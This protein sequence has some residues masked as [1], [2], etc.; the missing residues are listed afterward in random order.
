MPSS[1]RSVEMRIFATALLLNVADN[2]V[3]VCLFMLLCGP[4]RILNI[5]V[6]ICC[7]IRRFPVKD[8]GKSLK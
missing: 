2:S 8:D 6:F 7:I 4:C 5:L 3:T 1:D